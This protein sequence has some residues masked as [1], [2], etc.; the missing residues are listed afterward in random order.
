[1]TEQLTHIQKCL[2]EKAV[3][4]HG[5]ILLIKKHVSDNFTIMDGKMYFWYNT[6]DKSTHMDY[7]EIGKEKVGS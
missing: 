2:F 7:I 4:R 3:L 6:P 1:M 5:K